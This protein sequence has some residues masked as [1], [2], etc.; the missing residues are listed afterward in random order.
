MIGANEAIAEVLERIADLVEAQRGNPHRVRAY[1]SA[2]QTLRSLEQPVEAVLRDEGR[3]GLMRLPG[4]GRSMAALVDEYVHT[5][6][7][8]LLERLEGQVSP[9]DLFTTVPGVGEQL[10]HRIHD[11]L[12]VETLEELEL[13]AHD[14]RLESVPG[15]GPRR[16]RGIR[17]SLAAILGRSSRRHARHRRWVESGRRPPVEADPRASARTRPDVAVLLDVDA[18]YRRRA[19]AGEL[20]TIAPR[21]FN[22]E[23]RSWLPVLH[24]ERGGWAFTALYSNTARA[25]RLG[26]TRDWVVI[27]FERDGEEDQC[28]VVTEHRGTLAGRRVVRGREAECAGRLGPGDHPLPRAS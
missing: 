12:G 21:R 22:P 17:D 3:E 4:I 7:V 15:L 27:Y 5:A 14:G 20:R 23:G 2:A 24:T 10:A 13:A 11:S 25:H 16:A 8:A 9:E 6:R 26:T 28:T 19:E 1:R 18:E